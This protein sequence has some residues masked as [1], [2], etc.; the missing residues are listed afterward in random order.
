MAQLVCG[1]LNSGPV[2][3]LVIISKYSFFGRLYS[4]RK[5]HNEERFD[6]ALQLKSP[7]FP[8]SCFPRIS[9]ILSCRKGCLCITCLFSSGTSQQLG[10]A[11]EEATVLQQEPRGCETQ[12]ETR[13]VHG[14]Q[15]VSTSG[16]P[17]GSYTS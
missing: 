17:L 4:L 3:G 1:G 6:K 9:C 14:I 13:G 8:W 10:A 2:K 12:G 16:L 15:Q 5:K 11:T 7:S